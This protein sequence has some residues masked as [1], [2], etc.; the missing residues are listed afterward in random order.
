MPRSDGESGSESEWPIILPAGNRGSTVVDVPTRQAVGSAT[1]VQRPL[2]TKRYDRRSFLCRATAMGIVGPTLPF[3][4][5][6]PDPGGGVGDAAGD[7]FI[8]RPVLLPW[9]DD[10]V[11]ISAPMAELP[12]AYVSRAAQ[13]V[14]VDRESRVA[15]NVLLAAHISVS[16]GLWRIPLLGDDLKVPIPADDAVREF[17]ETDIGAWSPDLAPTKGDFRI[18]FGRRT[19]VTVDFDCAPLSG[20]GGWY[21]AGPLQIAQC[22]GIGE[23]PCLEAFMNVGSGTRHP[24]RYCAESEG[25]VELVTWACP[26]P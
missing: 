2:M 1:H 26:D 11:H 4:A 5:C 20:G 14:F 16:S 25:E 15:I 9:S 8:T 22:R 6:S 3:L 12:L 17:E 23:E 10:A 19:T 13:R 18:R 24:R 21:S 7:D